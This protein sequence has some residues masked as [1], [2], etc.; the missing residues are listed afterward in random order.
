M[1][2]T[3]KQFIE[4]IMTIIEILIVEIESQGQTYVSTND[5]RKFIHNLEFNIRV[6]DKKHVGKIGN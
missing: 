1:E 2:L 6:L 3:Q 5:L 4:R